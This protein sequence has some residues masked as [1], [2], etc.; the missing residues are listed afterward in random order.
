M[1][2]QEVKRI[3][4][5]YK[6]IEADLANTSKYIEPKGQENVFS[7][8]FAK[9]IILASTEL[10]SVF[11]QICLIIDPSRERGNIGEYRETILSEYPGIVKAT[12]GI[13]RLEKDIIPF[14]PWAMEGQHLTWWDAYGDIKHNRGDNYN[15]ATYHNAALAV[16]ALYVAIYYLAKISGL[17]TSFNGDY[18]QSEYAPQ[19]FLCRAPKDLPDFENIDAR[20][21]C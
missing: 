10:E 9:I 4:N 17:K 21:P 14:E 13:P 19:Y 3:W 11:K 5:Y 6:S 15:K 7:F 1:T 20:E 18:I 16:S 2:E 8:E 12:V